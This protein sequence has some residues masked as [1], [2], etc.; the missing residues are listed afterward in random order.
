MSFT[1][2]R[3][4]HVVSSDDS[5]SMSLS[6]NGTEVSITQVVFYT[7]Y[8]N[9]QCPILLD[10]ATRRKL[11]EFLNMGEYRELSYEERR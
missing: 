6:R 3:E 2:K 1:E 9:E 11:I 10:D 8:R 7:N 5:G 4:L